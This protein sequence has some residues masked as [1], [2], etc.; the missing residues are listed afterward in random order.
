ML[1]FKHEMVWKSLKMIEQQSSILKPNESVVFFTNSQSD[2][3]LDILKD[4]CYSQS[5]VV[6]RFDFCCLENVALSICISL[7]FLR[8]FLFIQ[9]SHDFQYIENN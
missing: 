2:S 6:F 3:M 9:G 8:A 4:N 5:N 1:Q 7:T